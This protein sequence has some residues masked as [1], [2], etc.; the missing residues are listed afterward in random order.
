MAFDVDHK[1]EGI[2]A[3]RVALGL[4][5]LFWGTAFSREKLGRADPADSTATAAD[6]AAASAALLIAPADSAFQGALP[7]DAPAD[8]PM[9]PSDTTLVPSDSLAKPA[10]A[11]EDTIMKKLLSE[12]GTVSYSG[13]RIETLPSENLVHI[14]EG[15]L[16]K[17][18]DATLSADSISYDLKKERLLADGHTSLKDRTGEITGTRMAYDFKLRK[19]VVQGAR[20]T[21]ENWIFTGETISKI[22]DVDIYGRNSNFTSC[23]L[24]EPH[25]HFRC[26]KLKLR[27][28]DKVIARPVIFFVRDIPLFALPF[29]IFPI[30]SGRK[31]GLLKPD[32]GIF[33]DDVRGRSITNL[34]YFWAASDYYDLTLAA[35]IYERLRKRVWGDFVYKKRYEYDGNIYASYTKD[36]LGGDKRRAEFR[37]LHDHILSKKATLKA[38]LNIAT[39]RD[40]YRDLSYDIDQVLQRS[41]KSRVTYDRREKWG[42][43]Y[44]SLDSDYSLERNQTTI[45]A[46]IVSIT[47]NSTSLFPASSEEKLPQWYGNLVY[48][49][50]GDFANKRITETRTSAA[51]TVETETK[52][53]TST[54]NANVT[55]PLRFFGWLNVNPGF[56]YRE[57][58][59]HS[60]EEGVG[61]LHQGT[62]TVSTGL[63]T[64]LYGIFD[65][66]RLGPVVKWRHTITPQITYSY[67]PAR[68]PAGSDESDYFTGISSSGT[69]NVNLSLSNDL[70]AKYLATEG[71]KTETKSLT[72][73][74]FLMSTSYNIK[75]ARQGQPGWGNLLS[76]LESSPS[77]RFKFSFQTT[78]SLYDGLHFDPFLTNMTTNF[79]MSGKRAKGAD[80]ASLAEE[81]MEEGEYLGSS[82]YG[83]ADSGMTGYGTAGGLSLR[84]PWSY[85]FTHN[86]SKSRTGTLVVQ[87]LR[88]SIGFDA[89]KK[90]RLLYSF[91][92]DLTHGELQDQSITL[93]RDLHEWELYISLKQLPGDRFSYEFRLNLKDIPA[94]E[95][96]RA[97]QTL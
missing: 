12:Q 29:Y 65:G 16:L 68:T 24:D 97:A 42:S 6:T 15:A 67:S 51:D 74:K 78:H 31:S 1:E 44:M 3:L 14:S 40:I 10:P 41:L 90:W 20:T 71:E 69:N 9:T 27:I 70:D 82:A 64:K 72:L 60:D 45:Q 59:F 66:P 49:L 85:T 52:L 34:G 35:D 33:S 13:D 38:D 84:G 28:N 91:Q 80:A 79:S 93:L 56:S 83:G 53:Q 86:L 95:F 30:E 32:F 89:S 47:K 37:V 2:T 63:L 43:Y 21:H 76:R 5:F 23:D 87:S 26:G 48:R 8:T 4:V 96:R 58:L 39:D 75:S 17:Y 92:Y 11:P 73:A 54:V 22:G 61:F 36:T 50:S 81:G 88:N 94:L 55:D 77:E 18:G 46:P 19:G 62:Y 7:T 25:Y 57:V